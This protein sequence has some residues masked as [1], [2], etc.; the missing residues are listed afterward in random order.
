MSDRRE[1]QR[2]YK[3]ERAKKIRQQP[4]AL[5]HARLMEVLHY[6]PETG[7]FSRIGLC[8]TRIDLVGKIAGG[9]TSDG[10]MRVAVDDRRYRAHRLAWFYMNG[11][12]PLM[13]I[14]HRD[15]NPKNNRWDNL[16]EVNS[17]IN[18]QNRRKSNKNSMVPFL[19]VSNAPCCDRFIARIDGDHIG[20]FDTPEDAHAAYVKVK[21][22]RHEG[23][24]I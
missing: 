2:I 18:K 11:E 12:W 24:T 23:C 14:D 10:Y 21:R 1:K 7:F 9:P 17:S 19:G 13:E 3:L 6:D 8:G 20:V 4:V 15:T 16:R 22:E 5:T